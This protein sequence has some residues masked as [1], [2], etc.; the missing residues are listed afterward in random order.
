[1]PLGPPSGP[2]VFFWTLETMDS[3]GL[4]GLRAVMGIGSGFSRMRNKNGGYPVM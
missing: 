2:Q 4:R 3:L 1:M